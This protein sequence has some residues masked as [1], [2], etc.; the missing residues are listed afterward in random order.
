MSGRTGGPA[1]PRPAV[2]TWALAHQNATTGILLG[3]MAVLAGISVAIATWL[4]RDDEM[5]SETASAVLFSTPFVLPLAIAAVLGGLAVHPR[6]W[7]PALGLSAGLWLGPI[8]QITERSALFQA[9]IALCGAGVLGFWV[10]GW[11]ARIPMWIGLGPWKW[12]EVQRT[13][14][15]LPPSGRP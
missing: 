2:M 8:G 14:E 10:A 1:R 6:G 13:D 5:L 7:V 3:L 11:V 4:T 9:G 12:V 15:D